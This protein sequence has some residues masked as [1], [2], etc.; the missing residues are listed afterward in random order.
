MSGLSRFQL[1]R[2]RQSII[3]RLRA[4]PVAVV[5]RMVNPVVPIDP[6]APPASTSHQINDSNVL[7]PTLEPSEESE[8]DNETESDETDQSV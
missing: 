6:S 5:R 8:S 3:G 7:E 4:Y 1:Y 2:E